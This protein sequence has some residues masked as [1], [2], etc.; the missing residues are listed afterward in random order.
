MLA[1]GRPL[2]SHLKNELNR[3]TPRNKPTPTPAEPRSW[4]WE[5][6]RGGRTRIVRP[7]STM[8]EGRMPSARR[9]STVQRWRRHARL[10]MSH[11]VFVQNYVVQSCRP[12]PAC[13]GGLHR[14]PVEELTPCSAVPGY[15]RGVAMLP[16]LV[17]EQ[18]VSR[19]G[20]LR[21]AVAWWVL[22][23]PAGSAEGV[24]R[25]AVRAAA[26]VPGHQ[27]GIGGR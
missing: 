15:V 3:N 23:A 6:G 17:G 24:G 13:P 22:A 4:W 9:S 16:D 10:F 18:C 11:G 26:A 21:Q 19:R 20:S 5:A 2:G 25:Q 14:P 7:P 8:V 12:S 27:R 1:G